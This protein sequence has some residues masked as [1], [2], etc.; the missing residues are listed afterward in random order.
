MEIK[1]DDP[2]LTYITLP[3]LRRSRSNLGQ[4][5]SIVPCEYCPRTSTFNGLNGDVYQLKMRLLFKTP[6]HYCATD[7]ANFFFTEMVCL[8]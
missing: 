5:S 8:P 4:F 6:K 3:P 2:R 1:T 7:V